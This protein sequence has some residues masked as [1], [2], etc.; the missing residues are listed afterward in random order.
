MRVALSAVTL[1]AL[2]GA[3]CR[4]ATAPPLAEGNVAARVAEGAPA[5]VVLGAGD[6]VSVQVFLH[7][8]S[9]TPEAG[10][11]LDS[12][13]RL[14]LPLLGPVTLAGRTLDEAR[15]LL[16]LE[17]ERYVREPRVSVHVLTLAS[18]RFYVFGEMERPGAFP[19]DRPLTA[20]QALSFAGGFRP[21][22]DR[23]KVALLRGRRE[24]LEVYFFDGATPGVDG[25]VT[26]QPDD[27]LFVRLSGAGT[28]RDQML[29]VVQSL[30]PPITGF[31]SLLL[32]ADQLNE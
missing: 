5:P 23:A 9:S 19:L 27:F 32:V 7:P 20:L 15:A 25:M 6:R 1:A 28:Y 18:R 3:A 17:F 12:E 22:A 31:A 13:G 24:A 14:D 30:M 2:L 21:G 10:A 29:P 4:W 11:L 26:I 8:E 16:T